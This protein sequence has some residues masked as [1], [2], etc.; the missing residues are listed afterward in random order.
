[1]NRYKKTG[2][3]M[4]LSINDKGNLLAILLSDVS[5]G[6]Y[7]TNLFLYVPGES[8]H[9]A[10][11]T[12]DSGLGISCR[13]TSSSY[14]AVLSEKGVDYVSYAGTLN[15]V[16]DFGNK[17]IFSA[18]ASTDGLAVC[19]A[20]ESRLEPN[21]LLVFDKSGK[22]LYKA[23]GMRNFSCLSRAGKTIYC[24]S[25]GL[26]ERLNLSSGKWESMPLVTDESKL[27]ALGSDSFLL[28]SSQKA[29]IFAFQPD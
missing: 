28:C 14:L 20:G 29:K 17:R 3:V 15:H 5:K 10:A 25:D 21:Q 6:R 2:Y 1:M 24:L 16:A 7:E 12:L 22:Q 9:K 23:S 4:D 11:V 27:L 26:V 19:L 18:D 13:F 8:T